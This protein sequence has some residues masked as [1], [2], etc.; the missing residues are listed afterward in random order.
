MRTNVVL[1]D[2]L[3]KKAMRCSNVKTKKKLLH[4]ALEEYVANHS[5]R[6][7]RD[8][9][10]RVHFRKGYDYKALRKKASS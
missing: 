4:I 2:L 8:L 5:R 3:V 7:L 9:K 6:D 10:G 1:E